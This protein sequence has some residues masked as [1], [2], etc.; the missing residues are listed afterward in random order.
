M[1]ATPTALPAPARADLRV[2]IGGLELRNPV[3][4]ASGCFG[5][6]LAPLIALERLGAVVT[7]TVFAAKRAGN[8]AH[9][10]TETAYGMLNSVGI[11]SPGSAG[12]LRT[13]LP[14]YRASGTNVIVSIGGLVT[15]EYFD[16]ARDLASAPIDA[17]EVNVS[18]PNLEHDGLPIGTSATRVAEVIAGVRSILPSVPLLVKLTP[19]VSDIAPIARAAEDAGADAVVVA[20]SFPGLVIDIATRQ[21]VLGNGAGGYTGPAVKPIALKL[22]NDAAHAVKIPVIGCGGIATAQDV[23]EFLI[24]GATAVQIGTATFT[25]PS[26]MTDIIDNLPSMCRH[27][28]VTRA[29]TLTGAFVAAPTH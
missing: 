8:P 29:S 22:V 14:A 20:N 2:N 27:L 10:L 1:S 26:T 19:A 16:V 21:S 12:F 3:M 23:V 17:F 7:K 13:V 5:P 11:P 4:P 15:P 18:C 28:S 6:E 9:R 24:A 25:R